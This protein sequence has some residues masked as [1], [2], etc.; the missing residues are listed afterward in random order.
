MGAISKLT[1]PPVA[2]PSPP[3]PAPSPQQGKTVSPIHIISLHA[4]ISERP[5]REQE[6]AE[7]AAMLATETL[8]R[9]PRLSRLLNYLCNKYFAGEGNELTEYSIAAEALGRDSRFDPQLDSAVR[10]DTHHLRKRLKECYAGEARDH[11]IQIVIP[12]GQ[13]IPQFLPRLESGVVPDTQPEHAEDEAV[14]DEHLVVAD[15]LGPTSQSVQRPGWSWLALTLAIVAIGTLLWVALAWSLRHLANAGSKVQN[16]TVAAASHALTNVQNTTIVAAASASDAIRILCGEREGNRYVDKSGRVWLPDRYF[17]GGTTFNRSS[18]EIARTQDPDIYRTGREGQF[19][20]DIPLKPGVYELHLYFAETQLSGEGM[21]TVDVSI[22]G[23]KVSSLDVDSDA[24]GPNV[25]TEKIYKDISPAEDGHLHVGFR[26]GPGFVNALEILPSTSGK[27]LPIRL[28][29][30]DIPYR[31]H[32]GQI[33]MPDQYFLSGRRTFARLPID[34]SKGMADAP[35]YNAHRFGN[36]TYSIPVVEGGKYTVTLYFAETWFT[37]PDKL[38]GVGSRVF[39]VY[40]NG[41][42]LLK[43]FDI[44]KDTGGDGD[45]PVVKVFHNIP[46]SAQGKL[47]LAFVP[48]KNYAMVSAIK[49]TEE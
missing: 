20:Y 26:G 38:G 5:S 13:Y 31:D 33:W 36:F 15:E 42:T 2:P 41:R 10:V 40:C 4:E 43:D 1:H 9:A 47:N 14:A 3:I 8:K 21:R 29:T 7:L 32:L 22:N 49:V 46:A 25:A 48:T 37:A 28:S 24:G 17:T 11:I 39:D 30:L 27:I 44:L 12:K 16:E 19:D 35:L 6:R 45:R 23:E 34:G 18:R